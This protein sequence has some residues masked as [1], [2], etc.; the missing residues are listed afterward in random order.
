MYWVSWAIAQ[1]S[2]IGQARAEIVER[3][4]ERLG[5][6]S[7]DGAARAPRSGAGLRSGRAA[8]GA[9][10]PRPGWRRSRA[11]RPA[12]QRLQR[13]PVRRAGDARHDGMRGLDPCCAHS[14]ASASRAGAGQAWR[15]TV[16]RARPWA[17]LSSAS[18]LGA[19]QG[20]CQRRDVGERASQAVAAGTMRRA[21]QARVELSRAVAKGCLDDSR[22]APRRRA[23]A[24]PRPRI[25]GRASSCRRRSAWPARTRRAA[26]RRAISHDGGGARHRR[27][28]RA[29]TAPA[30]ARAGRRARAACPRSR[31]RSG[32]AAPRQDLGR[33]VAVAEMPGEARQVLSV[34]GGD[35][36][37]VL[38]GRMHARASRRPRSRARRPRRAAA[39]SAGRAAR[40]RPDR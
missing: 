32:S 29:G 22:E 40:A 26:C 2:I 12:T 4:G 25:R 18:S 30:A 6:D 39:A 23:P 7:V 8:P 20:G 33:Q 37:H 5:G 11:G 38:V 3:G 13:Q 27:R 31:G 17:A 28:L 14:A 35:L 34:G 9:R 16:S 21:Q 10:R 19:A 36:Q 15:S 24:P 1:R